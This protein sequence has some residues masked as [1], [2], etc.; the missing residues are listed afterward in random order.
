MVIIIVWTAF[1]RLKQTNKQEKVC[2]NKDFCNVVMFFE[3]TKIL[4]SLINIENLIKHRLLFMQILNLHLIVKIDG[5]KNNSEKSSITKVREH[6]PS[7][8]SMSTILLFKDIENKHDVY[9]GTDCMKKMC[10]Y[11]REHALIIN[12]K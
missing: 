4:D 3:D 6:I 7:V 5:C 11:S 2:Q 1:I 10:E 8:F 12:F 9:R